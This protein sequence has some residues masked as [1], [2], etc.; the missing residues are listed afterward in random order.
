MFER[1]PAAPKKRRA[2]VEKKRTREYDKMTRQR[3]GR[4]IELRSKTGMTY[5]QIGEKICC[6]PA[7]ST[8]TYGGTTREEQSTST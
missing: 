3:L 6:S 5:K 2:K 4:A 7:P 8:K 1:Q